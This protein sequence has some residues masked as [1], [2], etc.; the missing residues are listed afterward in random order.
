VKEN[1]TA[2]VTGVR[3]KAFDM[4]S[5]IDS[6]KTDLQVAVLGFITWLKDNRGRLTQ[7]CRVEE[8]LNGMDQQ[9]RQQLRSEV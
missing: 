6:L 5:D 7:H 9:L 4:K 1:I 8:L 2:L 3:T